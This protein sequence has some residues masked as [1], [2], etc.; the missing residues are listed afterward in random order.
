LKN[1]NVH[2]LEPELERATTALMKSLPEHFEFPLPLRV[3]KSAFTIVAPEPATVGRY[4]V[5]VI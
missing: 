1:T 2:R 4:G 3:P 5:A